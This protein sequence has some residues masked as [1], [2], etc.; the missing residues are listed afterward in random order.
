MGFSFG[1]AAFQM[2]LWREFGRSFWKKHK[3]VQCDDGL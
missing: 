2:R 1:K 3:V